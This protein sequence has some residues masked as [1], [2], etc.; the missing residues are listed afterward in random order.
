MLWGLNDWY[1]HEASW[2]L[3]LRPRTNTTSLPLN[4][5]VRVLGPVQIQGPW[6]G[7]SMGI[8]ARGVDRRET[9]E[10]TATALAEEMM[11]A[12]D[13]GCC[14]GWWALDRSRSQEFHPPVFI[15]STLGP[16]LGSCSLFPSAFQPG[17]SICF[18]RPQKIR[19][20]L[21]RWNFLETGPPAVKKKMTKD[22]TR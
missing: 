10:Q 9:K 21:E 17:V 18:L 19:R 5:L 12:V 3:K 14:H 11:W 16:L 6:R 1:T 22:K 4:V 13:W 20:E 8:N 7:R 15:C 2:L